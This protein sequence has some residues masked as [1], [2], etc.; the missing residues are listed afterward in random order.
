MEDMLAISRYEDF[1]MH[2]NQRFYLS[3]TDAEKRHGALSVFRYIIKDL[4]GWTPQDAIVGLN[5]HVAKQMHIDLLM[6]YID[7][8]KD[9]L[10]DVDYD[11]LV[12]VAFPKEIPYKPEE[13]IIRNYKLVLQKVKPRFPKN[14][15]NRI[16]GGYMRARCV[17]AYAIDQNIPINERS[18]HDLY[19]LFAEPARIMPLLKSWKLNNVCKSLYENN[20][21]RYLHDTLEESETGEFLYNF[22]T[23]MKLYRETEQGMN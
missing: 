15:F 3:G 16:M 20:P 8:P 14:Y 23:F 11:Y 18:E 21:L 13:K 12:H 19:Q 22:H 4:L 1:L 6:T 7:L 5:Q 9:V 2:H 17:L 10:P